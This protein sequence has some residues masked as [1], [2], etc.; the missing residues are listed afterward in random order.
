MGPI[1]LA[2]WNPAGT[3]GARQGLAYCEP[4]RAG[5][6]LLGESFSRLVAVRTYLLKY[7]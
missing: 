4:N 6:D 7:P 1:L 3:K 5:Q 2:S